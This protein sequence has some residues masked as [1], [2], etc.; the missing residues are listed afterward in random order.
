MSEWMVLY[1]W[2]SVVDL[3]DAVHKVTSPHGR[4]SASVTS[5]L[6]PFFTPPEGHSSQPLERSPTQDGQANIFSR[7]YCVC[8]ILKSYRLIMKVSV[9][10]KWSLVS[11]ESTGGYEVQGR[12]FWWSHSNVPGHPWESSEILCTPMICIL[13]WKRG[14]S[15][16]R[17]GFGFF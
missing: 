17:G 14:D 5:Q 6:R 13:E 4:L 1:Y 10:I 3:W 7:S 12:F 8:L 11:L 15:N 2:Q 16:Q 9:T